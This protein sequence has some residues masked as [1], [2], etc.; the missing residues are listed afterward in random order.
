MGRSLMD[1]SILYH[2]LNC[3]LADKAVTVVA[4][5]ILS[6][7]FPAGA[8]LRHAR[9][10]EPEHLNG[11][12]GNDI[13]LIRSRMT[14]ESIDSEFIVSRHRIEHVFSGNRD[15]L[16]REFEYR[17]PKA[18][19]ITVSG[20]RY[21]SA[22]PKMGDT[23]IWLVKMRSGSVS[24]VVIPHWGISLPC[25]QRIDGNY[26]DVEALAVVLEE[27]S[28]L[29]GPARLE[30]LRTQA[31]SKAPEVGHWA[32]FT[33]AQERAELYEKTLDHFIV[34]KDLSIGAQ[35]AL[36]EALVRVQGKLWQHS[37]LRLALLQN[38]MSV[39]LSTYED[40]IVKH[41]LG[42][43][44]RLSERQGFGDEQQELVRSAFR[45]RFPSNA[46]E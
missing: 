6:L 40:A 13:C 46:E 12:P 17:H 26:Q 42:E 2:S 10:V 14:A 32:V 34:S 7:A 33:I 36:D 15:M 1:K 37:H 25:I 38:W 39:K 21:L 8:V 4:W 43:V 11:L 3:R 23:A 20:P 45:L 9:A 29:R 16:S 28:S 24:P 5:A 31:G 27:C 30:F 22:A 41:R 19:R 35:V 44:V 18:G